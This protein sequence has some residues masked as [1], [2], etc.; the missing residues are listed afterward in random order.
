VGAWAQPR[1]GETLQP[2]TLEQLYRRFAPFVHAR[3]TR[4]LGRDADMVVEELFVRL[5][6]SG[7]ATSKDDKKLAAWVLSTSTEL[8]LARLRRRPRDDADGEREAR[9]AAQGTED[10]EALLSRPEFCRRVLADLDR[11]T[12]EVVVLVYFEGLTASEAAAALNLPAATVEQD[13]R[14]Y[15]AD[16][17]ARLA[18]YRAPEPD[19]GAEGER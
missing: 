18:R 19:L 3:A 4:I 11:R 8:A 1:S 15:R 5:V 2:A 10:L 17:E 6:E 12:Q 7:M 14:H 9:S 16:A 13:L